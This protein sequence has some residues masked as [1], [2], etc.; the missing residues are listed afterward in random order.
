MN[1]EELVMSEHL[2]MSWEYGQKNYISKYENK[3]GKFNHSR[4]GWTLD[5]CT[6]WAEKQGEEEEEEAYKLVQV[7]CRT[8]AIG[9]STFLKCLIYFHHVFFCRGMLRNVDDIHI[10]ESNTIEIDAKQS[11]AKQIAKLL[12]NMATL[13]VWQEPFGIS[14]LCFSSGQ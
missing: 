8:N 13:C 10:N 4:D 12:S 11:K 1:V 5:C 14:I 9:T 7:L 3:N 6:Q 2:I